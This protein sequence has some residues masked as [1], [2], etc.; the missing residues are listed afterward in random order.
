M[1]S[2]VNYYSNTDSVSNHQ[3]NNE[4]TATARSGAATVIEESNLNAGHID[5]RNNR[6]VKDK[7]EIDRMKKAPKNSPNLMPPKKSRA[8]YYTLLSNM[9][10]ERIKFEQKNSCSFRAKPDR[11]PPLGGAR[12][13][14]FNYLFAKQNEGKFILRIEDTDKERSKKNMRMIIKWFK[15]AGI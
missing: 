2:A 4:P 8:R 10:N 14:A 12:T 15:M 1:G 5:F 9:K 7:T 6:I 3:R 11:R 13:A